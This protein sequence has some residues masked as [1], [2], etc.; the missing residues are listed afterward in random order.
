MENFKFNSMKVETT[1]L[2]KVSSYAKT[3]DASTQSVYNW[4]EAG[5]VNSVTIDG[6]TFIIMDGEAEEKEK[7]K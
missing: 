1:K 5:I 3:K 2:K 7:T 4:I 6:V